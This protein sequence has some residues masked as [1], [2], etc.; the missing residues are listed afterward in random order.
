[1][2]MTCQRTKKNQ[3]VK[4]KLSLGSNMTL[5]D[6]KVFIGWMVQQRTLTYL[7]LSSYLLY[8]TRSSG[9]GKREGE[10]QAGA[11]QLEQPWSQ[12]TVLPARLGKSH[13]N[14]LEGTTPVVPS[15]QCD[16]SLAHKLVKSLSHVKRPALPF[17]CTLQ[18]HPSLFYSLPQASTE[19]PPILCPSLFSLTPC[20]H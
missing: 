20:R 11:Q 3:T 13:L 16:L 1:M 9:V 19:A 17:P 8:W 14:T 10:H 6:P 12:A 2:Y 7:K 5:W 4:G 15:P 18:R